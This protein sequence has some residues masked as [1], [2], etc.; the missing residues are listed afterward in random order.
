VWWSGASRW[1]LHTLWRGYQQALHASPAVHPA[2]ATAR[3]TWAEMEAWL[4]Q[5]DAFGATA[6]VA[7]LLSPAQSKELKSRAR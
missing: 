5:L 2:R 1:S 3:G 4:H 6:L 7:K